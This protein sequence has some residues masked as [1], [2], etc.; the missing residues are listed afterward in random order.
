MY[1][2]QCTVC[3]YRTESE[4]CPSCKYS[5]CRGCHILVYQNQPPQICPRCLQPAEFIDLDAPGK[6]SRSP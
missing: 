2:W 3:G 5:N 4:R 1:N 6:D